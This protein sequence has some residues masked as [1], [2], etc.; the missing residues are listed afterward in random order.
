MRRGVRHLLLFAACASA[1]PAAAQAVADGLTIRASRRDT[2]VARATVTVVFTVS[3]R[4][5]REVLVVP[6]V[7]APKDWA[8]LTGHAPFPLAQRGTELLMFSV[9]VPARAAAGTYAVRTWVLSPGRDEVMDSVLVRV[10]QRRVLD[11]GL[12][13]RPGFVVAG[14]PYDARFLVRNRGNVASTLRISVGSTRGTAVVSDSTIDLAAEESRVVPVRVS[15]PPGLDAAMDDVL[16]LSVADVRDTITASASARI[17]LVPEP[18]R[19]IEEYQRVPIQLRVRAA[20]TDGVAPAELSGGGIIRDGGS[21]RL[22]FL[23]RAPTGAYSAYGERDE[24]SAE[25]RAPAW[26]VRAGDH[27]YMFSSLTGTGQP[28]LGGGAEGTLGILSA[29]AYA[30]QFR[31]LV[32][33]GSESGSFLSARPTPDSR[34]GV[35]FVSRLGGFSPGRIGS[36]AAAVQRDSYGGDIEVASSRTPGGSTGGARNARVGAAVARGAYEVGHLFADTGFLGTQRGSE[37][38]Y[39]TA[40]QQATENLS[41]ALS[42]STHRTDLSRSTGVPY[43]ERFAIATLGATLFNRYTTELSAV[44]RA[45]TVQQLRNRGEQQSV[46]ARG[47]HDVAFG[48]L[49]LEIEGGRS[50]D[51]T[52]TAG[53]RSYSELSL[54]LRRYLA[55]GSGAVWLDRYSGGSLTKGR[56]GTFTVGGDM[57]MRVGPATNLLVI[58]YATRVHAALPQWHS[59]LDA[60]VVHA[61]RNGNTLSLRAR[62]MSG[63]SLGPSDANLA[64]LE[65]ALPFRVP[66][67]RL[68]TPGRVHGR[69]VDA[70]SGRGVAGALVRLGPQVGITDQR[71]QVAFGNVPAGTHRLAMSQE[72]SFADAV[73]VGDPTLRI[74]ST[75]GRPTT[76]QLAI[77]RSA[78]VDIAV[79]RYSIARTAVARGADSL[80]DAGAVADAIITLTGERDTLYRT[81]GEGGTSSFTDIPPGRWVVSVRGDA[82]AFTRFDPDRVELTLAPGET[83]AVTFRLVPRKREVQIIGSGEELRPTAAEPKTPPKTRP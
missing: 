27:L 59:Q 64:Y 41:F 52:D 69:V 19:S 79:R 43:L 81:T 10:P 20:S 9:A 13:D 31:R 62:L 68:R 58:G 6:R 44:T 54:G 42:A 26:R 48:S 36:A 35:N 1:A 28:G 60:Q 3:N 4:A 57:T 16:E 24:Y 66:V 71:G 46:R 51:L 80:V 38:N 5:A 11:V 75:R 67:S 8:L 2:I 21:T 17:T 74:D 40:N 29:G 78:R 45:T 76:F 22:Q 12:I 39:L 18:S 70:T 50:R 55:R 33:K 56:E 32:E 25:L 34:V 37:H 73:F 14:K 7:E 83:R 23:L 65:Y 61:L 63:G 53:M 30:Q 47:D 82:P 77:A 72:T 15:S 49:T